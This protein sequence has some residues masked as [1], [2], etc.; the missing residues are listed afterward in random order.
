MAE[1]RSAEMPDL[2][3][4]KGRK[5]TDFLFLILFAAFWVG[6]LI[7][8][9]IGWAE[10]DPRVLIYGLDYKGN[11][12]GKDN[13]SPG[14]MDLGDFKFQYWPNTNQ[15]FSGAQLQSQ[16]QVAFKFDEAKSICL[17]HCPSLPN[18]TNTSDTNV[19][20]PFVCDYP[21][22]INALEMTMEQWKAANYD[23]YASL[24][25]TLKNSSLALQGPCYPVTL[26][27]RSQYWSCQYYGSYDKSVTDAWDAMGGA[28]LA[29]NAEAEIEQ[30]IQDFL[31]DPVKILERYVA[32][33]GI[34][35]K[36][37]VVCGLVV[38]IVACFLMLYLMRF[39]VRP[40][41]YLTLLLVNV[42]ALGATLFAFAKAGWIGDDE[43]NPFTGE[44][45][46]SAEGQ[47]TAADGGDL[48]AAEDNQTVMKAIAVMMVVVTGLI[49]LFTIAMLSKIKVGIAVL[50]VSLKAVVAN[51][52]TVF[53]P[54][55][56]VFLIIALVVYAA[57]TAVYLFSA[58]DIERNVCPEGQDDDCGWN[59][60]L[61]DDLKK[62]LVYVFFG[63][64]WSL[65]FIIGVS[66]VT[67]AGVYGEYYF[68]RGEAGSMP[69]KSSL[70]RTG[71]Y[72]LG[73][74]ALGS[75]IIA[76][77]EFVRVVVHY[78]KSK[79]ESTS[80]S[81]NA[82]TAN[83]IVTKLFCFVQCCLCLLDMI[84]KYIT[85][86][87][88]IVI[89]LTGASYCSAS[90]K[91]FKI[92][93]SNVLQVAAVNVIG[94]AI[95]FLG[96][97]AVAFG[98]AVL[99]YAWLDSETYDT[100]DEAVSS[101]I[102]PVLLVFILA[103]GIATG[104]FGVAEM[105]VDTVLMAYLMDADK[106]GGVAVNAP[107]ELNASLDDLKHAANAFSAPPVSQ[108]AANQAPGATAI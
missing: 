85:R 99:A 51:P 94:D 38:P 53:F 88:Y 44:G 73:S 29:E 45:E 76:L 78:M 107:P 65:Y 89:A 50:K 9:G 52:T 62:M 75:F 79:A 27:S 96:K 90:R 105:A 80:K 22:D 28:S 106:N 100:G 2:D 104:I 54:L 7:A 19:T 5:C 40:L 4:S 84:I 57:V 60:N 55:L 58:G 10:G 101:P 67:L 25:E 97:L 81:V 34:A 39:F 47:L 63:F 15:L 56:P 37:E 17:S 42:A 108:P 64:L 26:A 92:L 69:L 98:C 74:V 20:V 66:Y 31:K 6:M 102:L 68:R 23:Y 46:Q 77:V 48:D 21:E 86:Q 61:N 95:L 71:R 49:F 3:M 12:C 59:V 82:G 91:V 103:Y 30:K 33:V 24:N 13:G 36:V 32:D 41:T 87:A 72:H 70:G 16:V 35:W 83:Q 14:N 1:A 43:L 93:T 18:I 8:S 11:V